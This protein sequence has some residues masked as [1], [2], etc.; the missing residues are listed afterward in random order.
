MTGWI[1]GLWYS[2]FPAADWA[3]YAL[4]RV[5]TFVSL[6]ALYFIARRVAGPRRALFVVLVMMLYP[7]FHTKGE[8][9][10][11][12]QVLLALLPLLVLTFLDRLRE[13]QRAVGRAAR[14]RGSGLHADD[15]F[16]ADRRRGDR[17]CGADSSASHA[18]PA[19]AGA[20]DRG[21]SSISLALTP[22]LLWLVK[23]NYPTLQWASSLAEQRGTA[24]RTLDYLGHHFALL[25][26]PAAVGAALLVA[27]R[28]ARRAS[29]R[30]ASPT[31]SWSWSS[32]TVLVFYPADRGA[33]DG[34]L[35]AARLGQSAV[36]PR[37]AHLAGA[38][39][40]ARNTAARS[41]VPASRRRRS[42]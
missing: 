9:F 30:G 29:S 6:A 37:A 33:R 26:I 25:A 16:G 40:A 42:R 41:R 12:Y 28:R 8:R 21:R 34:Q 14:P 20:V 18:F 24:L 32:S 23:W 36:L 5:M 11:N 31:R 39:S 1:A 22:H 13:A 38:R 10:N 2:V 4:S 35:S 15:L 19:L 27:W 7:L 17:P 3:S